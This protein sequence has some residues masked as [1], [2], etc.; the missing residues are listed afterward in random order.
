MTSTLYSIRTHIDHEGRDSYVI[1]KFVDGEVESSY[2]TSREACECPAGVRPSCRHRQMLPHM[3]RAGIINTHWFLT[4]PEAEVVDFQGTLRRNLEALVG[5]EAAAES[6]A[7]TD[8]SDP[9]PTDSDGYEVPEGDGN[10]EQDI[11][12]EVAFYSQP[13]PEHKMNWATPSAPEPFRRRF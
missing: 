4:W 13:K 8:L 11:R 6:A 7:E 12:E 9:T 2:R 10:E 1:T 5:P 3:L